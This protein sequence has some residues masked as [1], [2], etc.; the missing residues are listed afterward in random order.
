LV[1][2]VLLVA[3]SLA[4]PWVFGPRTAWTEERARE[5][6]QVG[7]KLHSLAHR[8]G[9]AE[10]ARRAGK[11]APAVPHPH[12][13]CHDHECGEPPSD[14]QI[15]EARQRF[16]RSKAQL[17]QARRSGRTTAAALRVCGVVCVLFGGGGY[18]LLRRVRR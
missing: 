2:G 11:S 10:D 1:V 7:V 16:E 18:L 5:H 13:D 6:A 14:D 8:R 3:V 9:H 17:E 12:A 4:I 15:A